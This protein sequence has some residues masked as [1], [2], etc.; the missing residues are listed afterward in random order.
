M[1]L[2]LYCLLAVLWS[3]GQTH[4]QKQATNIRPLTIG[5][6]L[7]SNLVIENVINHPVSKIHVSDLKGKIVVLDFWATWCMSCIAAMPAMEN[8]QSVFKDQIAILLTNSTPSD[9]SGKINAFIKR[10]QQKGY[11]VRL[12]IIQQDTVLNQYFPHTMVPHY[13]WLGKNLEVLAITD[14]DAITED[15][16]RKAIAGK[17]LHLSTKNDALLF[18]AKKPLLVD[19]NGGNAD[20]FVFRSILTGEKEGLGVRAGKETTLDGDTKRIYYINYPLEALLR[21]AFADEF[22]QAFP[23]LV[24]EQF[25]KDS[26][27][28]VSL[29][30]KFC[31]ELITRP[32]PY[33]DIRTYI[34]QDIWRNF[35]LTVK[36]EKR[37]VTFYE[38]HVKDANKIPFSKGG[39]PAYIVEKAAPNKFFINQSV[40]ALNAL[41]TTLLN[42]PVF[43]LTHLNRNIDLKLP[44]DIYQYDIGK[45]TQLLSAYGFTLLK[46]SENRDVIVITDKL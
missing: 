19:G 40:D 11:M 27:N 15:N 13:V 36:L 32:V 21:S 20:E 6:T 10:Q 45:L 8:L 4:A 7:P 38:L 1:K 16:I 25:Q 44:V 42:L 34:R 5:E 39:D 22:T 30:D 24:I 3:V 2:L 37:L 35:K 41:A 29:D 33:S 23:E 46:C 26:L 28:S 9:N 31:Y 12:P 43:N 14:K 18:D 17:P